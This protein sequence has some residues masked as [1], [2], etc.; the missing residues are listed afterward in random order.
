MEK[1][2]ELEILQMKKEIIGKIR[3]SVPKCGLKFDGEFYIHYIEGE[4][5]TTEICK[6]IAWQP[7][8]DEIVVTIKT[9]VSGTIEYIRE[10]DLVCY[11]PYSLV[12]ILRNC[13]EASGRIKRTLA[14]NDTQKGLVNEFVNAYKK[15]KD[16]NVG[17]ISDR[18]NRGIK[19]LNRENVELFDA[20]YK[21]KDGKSPDCVDGC[22]KI[23]DLLTPGCENFYDT[24]IYHEEEDLY[25][26]LK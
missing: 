5:A 18:N 8:E 10:D 17:I 16:A 3:N 19:F 26:K 1:N 12:D 25:A 24:Y 7:G 4:V 21:D 6:A 11:D 14:L 13:E 22:Y 9:E 15:L 20:H 23:T 2:Y